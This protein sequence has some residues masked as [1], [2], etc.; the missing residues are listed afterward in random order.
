[1]R[2]VVA[3]SVVLVA[4]VSNGE[5]VLVG[6]A[7][8]RLVVTSVEFVILGVE[9]QTAA[10]D[11]LVGILHGLL[12][13][14]IVLGERGVLL[15]VGDGL[16]LLSRQRIVTPYKI[17]TCEQSLGSLLRGHTGVT[18]I[19]EQQ[20]LS[21]GQVLHDLCQH[22]VDAL[23]LGGRAAFLSEYGHLAPQL[24]QLQI[25]QSTQELGLTHGGVVARLRHFAQL[26]RVADGGDSIV[27][28]GNTQQQV[29][30]NLDLIPCCRLLLE[31]TVHGT[32]L[33]LFTLKRDEFVRV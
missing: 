32:C 29:V 21:I 22:V 25:S 19:V 12:Q 20:A 6:A 1:M 11:D 27:V 30:E 23:T 24:R 9:G 10:L 33:A 14:G 17:G 5:E 18:A 15:G 8:V 4:I 2:L 26:Q 16:N 3:L 7:L 13:S 28:L 31:S